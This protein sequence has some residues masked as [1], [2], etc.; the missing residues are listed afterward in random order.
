MGIY[1][2]L[3]GIDTDASGSVDKFVQKA[4]ECTA[5]AAPAPVPTTAA[6]GLGGPSTGD[7][8]LLAASSTSS[9]ALLYSIAGA[10]A[11][12]LAGVATLRFARR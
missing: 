8:G 10:L 2:L 4:I 1:E 3:V 5:P 9:S 7:G 6:A 12:A 11:F